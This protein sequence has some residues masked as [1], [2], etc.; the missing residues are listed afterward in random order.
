MKLIEGVVE[1]ISAKDLPN[2]EDQWGNTCRVNIKV[3]EDWIGLGTSKKPE[4]N[5]KEGAGWH[6][7]AK[8]D[9]IAVV[10]EENGQ[11]LNAKKSDIKVKSKGSGI[12]NGSPSRSAAGSSAGRTSS[13]GS[14]G[15][16]SGGTDW[17]RKDAGAAASASVDKAIAYLTAVGFPEG[18]HPEG[19]LDRNLRVILNVARE[20]QGIVKTLAEEILNEGKAPVTEEKEAAP[21]LTMT[22]GLSKARGG[23]PK[24]V[25]PEPDEFVD[26]EDLF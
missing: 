1:A 26:D 21:K 24:S 16:T 9:T 19:D 14:T 15:N 3:G 17:A 23:K 22:N 11:W 25:E 5:I 8:G 6:K 20:M 7:L 4:V 10:V 12:S 13:G 2:G 18:S